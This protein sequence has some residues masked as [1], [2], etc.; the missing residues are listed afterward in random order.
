M[1]WT[2]LND[3]GGGGG[4]VKEKTRDPEAEQEGS[5]VSV[6][7]TECSHFRIWNRA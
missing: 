2:W 7:N 4:G 6:R 1:C 5:R 3:S